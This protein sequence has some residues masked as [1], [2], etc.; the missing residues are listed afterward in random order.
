M[1]LLHEAVEIS[2]DH[3]KISFSC[4]QTPKPGQFIS[5]KVGSGTDP[6][7]RRPFSIYDYNNNQIDIIV[8]KTGKATDILCQNQCTET[9][10]ATGPFGHGFSITENQNTLLIGGGVGNAPLHYL[11]NRLRE[12]NNDVTYIYGSQNREFIY[13]QDNFQKC[14]NE[15]F[16]MTDDGSFGEKGFVTEK[17]I[18]M[19]N[20]GTLDT[21]DKIYVCG[22][23]LMMKSVANLLKEYSKISEFSLE[24]YFGCGIGI[25]SG[26]SVKT[27]DGRKR[28][29]VDGPVF[30]LE[31]II[32]EFI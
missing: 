5:V 26:C 7:L 31:D 22:P 16:F 29:C 3:F 15:S 19:K 10:E 21:F 17:L 4:D 20:D 24:N 6:L 27:K 23:E 2:K 14:S 28:A 32:P 25:C 12:K 30:T 9:T 11:A 8:K 13:C 1:K 18:K